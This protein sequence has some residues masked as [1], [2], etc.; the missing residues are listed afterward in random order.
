[1]ASAINL[2]LARG[3]VFRAHAFELMCARKDI[4]Q[5]PTKPSHPRTNGQVERMNRTLKE[6]SARTCHCATRARLR[7]RLACLGNA[8]LCQTPQDTRRSHRL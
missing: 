6:A 7:A 5:R 2:A 4:G 8:Q 3:G 1:M